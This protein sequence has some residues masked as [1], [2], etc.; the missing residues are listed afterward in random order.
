M[1][2]W[3]CVSFVVK[4]SFESQQRERESNTWIGDL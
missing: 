3:I 2:L 4:E 1:R